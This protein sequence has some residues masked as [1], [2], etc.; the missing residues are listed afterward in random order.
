VATAP[1][2]TIAAK[3]AS[4]V[5]FINFSHRRLELCAFPYPAIHE[6]LTRPKEF[7]SKPG[8]STQVHKNVFP[9][10]L[11]S[12]DIHLPAIGWNSLA[13]SR[14]ERPRVPRTHHSLPLQPSLPQRSTPVRTPV[15]HGA[16][17]TVNIS[18]ANGNTSRL[19]LLHLTHRGSL[20]HRT[21]PNP[22]LQ[23]LLL[24]GNQLR[25]LSVPSSP[26]EMLDKEPENHA[27]P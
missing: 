5:R 18:Q 11:N 22:L 9:F 27:K 20:A 14:I 13:R 3:R 23:S 10:D 12:I 7:S 19:R 16:Q 1:T 6:S 25:P 21:Q 8:E 15:V 4:N 26:H 24:P 17:P 2:R